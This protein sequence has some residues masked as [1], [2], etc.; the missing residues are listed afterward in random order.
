MVLDSELKTRDRPARQIRRQVRWLHKWLGLL[1]A[2]IV[3]ASGVTGLLLLNPQWL[4]VEELRV[5]AVL[6]HPEHPEIQYRGTNFGLEISRNGGL[7]W[8]EVPMLMSPGE[9]HQIMWN[10]QSA[11]QIF[12]LGAEGLVVSN[13]GGR[14]WETM[15]PPSDVEGA[16]SGFQ[17]LSWSSR[18]K[19]IIATRSSLW[20]FSFSEGQWAVQPWED[21]SA[22]VGPRQWVHDLHTGRIWGPVGNIILTWGTAVLILVT[23]SGLYL[24]LARRNGKNSAARLSILILAVG[25]LGASPGHAQEAVSR[26]ESHYHEEARWMM[27]TLAVL[28]CWAPSNSQAVQAVVEAFEEMD[29]LEKVFSTWKTD[30]ELSRVN[31]VADS[32]PVSVSP[33]LAAVLEES[34]G[35]AKT[36]GGAFD[37]TVLPLVKL[38][39]FRESGQVGIPSTESI[40]NVRS[41]TG[42]QQISWDLSSRR[43]SFCGPGMS[44]DFGAIAKGYALDKA[45]QIM[46][47]KGA[48]AGTLDLGGG[49][50]V[51]GKKAACRVGV[52][53]PSGD[54]TV[55]EIYLEN[56]AMAT[57]GQYER[58]RESEGEVWGHILD[59]RTGYPV[60]HFLS[61][62]VVS[63]SAMLADATATA[64]FVLGKEKGLEF[65]E[66]MPSS[67]GVFLVPTEKGEAEVL[68]T[69]G[70]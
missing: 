57:S 10:P 1:V 40:E 11:N 29:R 46:R 58:Y 23:L 42:Y 43:V 28:G 41:Q 60:N 69:T 50:L 16:W 53:D 47:Q 44:L 8:A 27:G 17:G 61:V 25:S 19:I 31:S 37:P 18:E 15:S 39:G 70:W 35:L 2:L 45:A 21:I 5:T 32:V 63:E 26:A 36:S 30:S 51:F 49:L 68:S 14:I 12:C 20:S 3:L 38:W 59:P 67:E 13:D 34:L 9:I 33:D 48:V 64:C 54:G 6:A 55:G 4:G 22:G 7:S 62:T 66:K 65:L 24:G 52:V 56:A